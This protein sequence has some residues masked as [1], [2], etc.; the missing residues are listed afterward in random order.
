MYL[1]KTVLAI[2]LMSSDFSTSFLT[3]IEAVKKKFARS[4]TVSYDTSSNNYKRNNDDKNGNGGLSS[5]SI[6]ELKRL[7]T[8]RNIDFRD[9]LEKRDLVDRLKESSSSSKSSPLSSFSSLT[10]PENRLIQT[11]K[12]VSPGVAYIQTMSTIQQ[13]RFALQG[14]EVPAG[15]GSGFLWD[16]AGHIVTNYHVVSG[17]RSSG[18]PNR[19]RVKLQ[20]MAESCHATVVGVEP[21]K[22]LAVLKLTDRN[23]LRN[24]PT[25]MDIGTSNDLQVGQSVLAIGNPFGLD[26]TLTTGVVSAL[27]RDVDGIGGRPIK[28]CIQTDAAI[29]PGNSG[30]PLLDSRGRLIGVNTAI[31]SPG[32]RNGIGGN[33]GIGFAVPVDTVRRVVNQIIR[34]GRV[35]RPTM[36]VNVADDRIVRSIENQLQEKLN[37]VLI[38]EVLPNSPAQ[39]AGLKASELRSDG[40]IVL[41]DLITHVNGNPVRQVEDLL[42]DIEERSDGETVVLK[43][44]RGCDKSK[45]EIF[46]VRLTTN[47]GSNVQNVSNMVGYGMTSRVG[48]SDSD[49]Q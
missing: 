25:P 45:V 40:S 14:L 1:K 28:G 9:C 41:G 3:H 15:T 35:V 44:L 24:L 5:L 2:F 49:W 32:A 10:D 13:G 34:Y 33:I 11:F 16:S 26:D 42:S 39:A 36:G 7:L 12:R 6:S 30:G 4:T 31:F 29:N 8:D 27:G 47:K 20:G 22:D 46:R 17:G 37:G 48:V 43:V 21:E 23:V 19:V 38:V 18:I